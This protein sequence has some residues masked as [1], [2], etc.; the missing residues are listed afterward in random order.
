MRNSER[1]AFWGQGARRK[2]LI[3]GGVEGGLSFSQAADATSIGAGVDL[4]AD[5]VAVGRRAGLRAGDKEA[6]WA[7]H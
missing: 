4:H 7:V 6:I 3:G 1:A 2:R 5:E